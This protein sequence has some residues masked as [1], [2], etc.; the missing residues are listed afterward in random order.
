M[1]E[2]LKE[3]YVLGVLSIWKENA[4]IGVDGILR[5]RAEFRSFQFQILRNFNISEVVQLVI[6]KVWFHR[7]KAHFEKGEVVNNVG[8]Y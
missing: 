2:V 8:C 1:Y 5:I 3:I 7:G 4:A 6:R